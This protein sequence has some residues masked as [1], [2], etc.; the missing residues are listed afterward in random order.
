MILNKQEQ[1]RLREILTH[2][3]FEILVK[4]GQ[5][6]QKAIGVAKI[7]NVT[8]W[9]FVKASLQKEYQ[10]AFIDEFFKLMEQEAMGGSDAE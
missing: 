7:L 10:M 2:K 4:F 5:E 3:D 6:L 1:N 9:D 8:Q